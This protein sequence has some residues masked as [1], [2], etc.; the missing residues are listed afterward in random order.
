MVR[1]EAREGAGG[2]LN[3]DHSW[4]REDTVGEMLYTA[5]TNIRIRNSGFF[6][7]AKL[8]TPLKLLSVQASRHK[9]RSTERS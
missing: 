1:L 4:R 5:A 3:G 6:F 9:H 8:Y 2:P 7:L